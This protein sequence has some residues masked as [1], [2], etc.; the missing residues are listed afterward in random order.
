VE[1]DEV[2]V[3]WTDEGDHVVL[4]VHGGLSSASA[5]LTL[6]PALR[7]HLLDRGRV[8]VDLSEAT[9]QWAPVAQLFPAALAGTGGW[10]LARLVLA[11]PDPTVAAI[12][13]AARVHLAVPVARNR[14]EARVLLDVRPQRVARKHEVPCAAAAPGLA[15]TFVTSMCD[16]WDLDLGL[17]DA[18]MTVVTELVNNAVEHARTECVLFL[19]FD[20]GRLRIAVRDH[21]SGAEGLPRAGVRGDRGYGLLMV[22][23]MSRSW[24]V[25][26]HDDGKTVWALLDTRLDTDI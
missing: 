10:P 26:T 2:T 21:R 6:R 17:G 24:G 7:K 3:K 15:R 18:A 22:E 9:V 20:R 19:A 12:L 16:D 8:V 1:P 11:G 25:T 14:D 5:N 13:R 4:V 23:G